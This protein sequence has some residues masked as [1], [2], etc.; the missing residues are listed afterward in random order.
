MGRSFDDSR[1]WMRA[2]TECII[3]AARQLDDSEL[4]LASSLPQWTRKH[5]VAHVA[6]NA[7]ALGNLVHW[8]ATGVPTP[9]YSSPQE[10]AEGIEKGSRLDGDR[11]NDWLQQS[12]ATLQ[13]AADKLRPVDWESEIVTAQGR[14]VQATEI[15]W[16]RSREVWVHAVDLGTGVTFDDLPIG[17]L[18]A[19][20][21]DVIMKRRTGQSPS[22]VLEATDTSDTW[23]LLGEGDPVR[24]AAPLAQLT[25]Y[26]T[27]RDHTVTVHDGTAAPTLGPWL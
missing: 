5:L 21:D 11:L 26:L 19:L 3:E 8:A 1:E 20:C 24:V 16:M 4:A 22:L 27:G 13:D 25:A 12:A 10:R 18:A 15:P 6:A 7:D 23:E 9:M 2:G 14:T 17:F